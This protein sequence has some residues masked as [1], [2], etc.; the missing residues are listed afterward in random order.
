LYV[1]PKKQRHDIDEALLITFSPGRTLGFMPSN[2]GMTVS[3]F[4]SVENSGE[5]CM[6]AKWCRQDPVTRS[7]VGNFSGFQENDAVVM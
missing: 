5:C 2:E 6:S 7:E 1:T 4:N 3:S